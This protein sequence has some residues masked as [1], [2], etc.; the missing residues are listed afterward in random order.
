MT[1]P[2]NQPPLNQPPTP[3]T[4]P[5]EE[6]RFEQWFRGYIERNEIN[7]TPSGQSQ[8]VGTSSGGQPNSGPSLEAA[9]EAA[10]TRREQRQKRD[11]TV[12]SLQAANEALKTRVDALEQLVTKPKKS[13]F[14][15][16]S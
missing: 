12:T 10:M 14:S 2:V 16:F 1:D 15:I 8:S 5:S 3:P 7:V 13:V 11:S 6:Q 9:I 4:V